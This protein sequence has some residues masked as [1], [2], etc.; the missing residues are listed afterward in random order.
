MQAESTTQ[1]AKKP[2]I[3]LELRTT[4]SGALIRYDDKDLGSTPL[5]VSLRSDRSHRLDLVL[6]G[7]ESHTV[8]V[9]PEQLEDPRSGVSHH[10]T[11]VRVGARPSTSRRSSSRP[12]AKRVKKSEPVAPQPQRAPR[13]RPPSEKPEPSTSEPKLK[14]PGKNPRIEVLE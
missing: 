11:L 4:P 1:Q 10:V 5:T 9:D 13:I 14:L 2:P 3:A 12:R 7:Y 8:L 6:K